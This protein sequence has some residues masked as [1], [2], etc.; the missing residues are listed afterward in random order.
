MSRHDDESTAVTRRREDVKV[1]LAPETLRQLAKHQ[2]P[3]YGPEFLRA[4]A[5]RGT[6]HIRKGGADDDKGSAFEVLAGRDA[7]RFCRK[8]VREQ[9]AE[10][11]EGAGKGKGKDAEG[12][13]GSGD[14]TVVA[15]AESS[16]NTHTNKGLPP[17]VF[18]LPRTAAGDASRK[19]VDYYMAWRGKTKTTRLKGLA[20]RAGF[21]DGEFRRVREALDGEFRR[22]SR[23]FGGDGKDG[24]KSQS[25]PELIRAPTDPQQPPRLSP[26]L[27][28]RRS[29]DNDHDKDKS[30]R[31]DDGRERIKEEGH[32][33][34]DDD[35]DGPLL[36]PPRLHL[37]GLRPQL[38]T[39][40]SLDS[41]TSLP[42][43]GTVR[44][45]P[46]GNRLPLRVTNP[47]DR[48]SVS[49]SGSASM[50]D[51][52][53]SNPPRGSPLRE[54]AR[55]SPLRETVGFNVPAAED[56]EVAQVVRR[57]TKT[58][59][60]RLPGRT[61]SD[62]SGVSA[63]TS[64]SSSSGRRRKE[65]KNPSHDGGEQE[66]ILIVLLDEKDNPKAEKKMGKDTTWHGLERRLS[67]RSARK[68]TPPGSAHHSPWMGPL[69]HLDEDIK[70]IHTPDHSDHYYE[71][72]DSDAG[73]DWDA[74]QHGG[75]GNASVVPI[76]SMLAAMGYLSPEAAFMGSTGGSPYSPY[77]GA[78]LPMQTPY[79]SPYSTTSAH[80][81]SY[82]S[83]YVAPLQSSPYASPY[84]QLQQ[85]QPP[86][87]P[88]TPTYFGMGTPQMQHHQTPLP[89]W[90][91][92]GGYGPAPGTYPSPAAGYGPAAYASPNAGYAGAANLAAG[93]SSPYVPPLQ[94]Q[95]YYYG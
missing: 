88:Q 54:G 77:S 23:A 2:R 11:K 90:G 46:T 38:A 95:G 89:T 36:P 92:P 93:Y 7:R 16:G 33:R 28:S 87:R 39:R 82:S 52:G 37:D 81:A 3:A 63:S 25:A 57:G 17:V 65:K 45:V 48:M 59:K 69:V 31:R 12:T 76:Q 78:A 75:G 60:V 1:E 50:N 51:Q 68:L 49:S 64:S 5:R 32:E 73:S 41:V 72:S 19:V 6:N 79:N 71:D 67:S 66:K 14:K 24:N 47:G 70:Y 20:R 44:G 8:F 21:L 29:T 27:A 56:A 15:R 58:H 35:D 43:L 34:A 84:Q 22:A 80:L 61:P 30:R 94:S 91:S 10:E 74:Q 55:S 85:L 42:L 83:P 18:A 4:F 26:L 62:S 13:K 9:A 40:D 86:S 53:R